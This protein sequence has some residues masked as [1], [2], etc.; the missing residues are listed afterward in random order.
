MNVSQKFLFKDVVKVVY[1]VH[2]VY[3]STYT[4]Q[5]QN[6]MSDQILTLQTAERVPG[7]HLH[8]LVTYLVPR[9]VNRTGKPATK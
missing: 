4:W 6:W 3:F 7:H 8:H 9:G 2:D 5:Y 1:R